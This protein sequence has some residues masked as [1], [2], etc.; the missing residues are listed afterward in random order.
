[1]NKYFNQGAKK[2]NNPATTIQFISYLY[3]LFTEWLW[4]ISGKH[5]EYSS[6]RFTL[7]DHKAEQQRQMERESVEEEDKWT[8]SFF[9]LS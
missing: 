6:N 4:P 3:A 9:N 1:M 8:D 7:S 2:K 5:G